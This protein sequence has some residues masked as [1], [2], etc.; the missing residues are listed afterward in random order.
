ML[1]AQ[2]VKGLKEEFNITSNK[3][4]AS[5]KVLVKQYVKGEISKQGLTD[6]LK[7]FSKE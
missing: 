1:E 2:L 7:G 6:L 3:Y 4:N 5:I